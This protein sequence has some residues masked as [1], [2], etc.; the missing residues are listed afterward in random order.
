[1]LK[2]IDTEY[3]VETQYGL[4]TREWHSPAHIR[5]LFPDFLSIHIYHWQW[6]RFDNEIGVA[7]YTAGGYF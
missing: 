2:P 1:M 6:R 7:V 3:N 5:E 4:Y